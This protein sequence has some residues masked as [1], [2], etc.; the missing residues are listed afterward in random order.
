MPNRLFIVGAG[1]FGREVAVWAAHWLAQEPAFVLHGFLD[2]NA[3]ALEG[4]PSDLPLLGTPGAFEFQPGDGALIAIGNPKTR[5]AVANVLQ[6]RVTFPILIHPAAIVGPHCQLGEGSIVCPTTVLT[7]NVR[8]GKHVIANLGCSIGHDATLGDFTTL[9]PHVSVSGG[10][11]TGEGVFVGSNA[12][13]VPLVKVG[14]GAV[15]GAGSLVL[16]PVPENVTVFGLPARQ[17]TK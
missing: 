1:G 2:D 14:A 4:F 10:A 15:I 9:S 17:H 13:L 7:T 3:R 11:I 6:G 12:S 8:F 16:R 5:R